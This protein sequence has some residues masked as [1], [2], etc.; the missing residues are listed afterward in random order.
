MT[1]AALLQQVLSGVN[2]LRGRFTN[3]EQS[4]DEIRRDQ[5]EMR[6]IMATK[7]DLKQY[8][9][10]ETVD[11]MRSA[12]DLRFSDLSSRQTRMEDRY[13]KLRDGLHDRDV[14]DALREGEGR[15]THE[16]RNSDS[17]AAIDNR[18]INLLVAAATLAI[19][20][21]VWALVNQ[22]QHALTHP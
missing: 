11:G 15:L 8:A 3:I 1:P 2:E 21:L 6:G 16:V 4:V 10:N 14:T 5:H 18:L 7:E 9:R 20:P 13:D 12:N 17:R 22:L 19:S